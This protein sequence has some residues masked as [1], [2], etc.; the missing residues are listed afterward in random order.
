MER[1]MISRTMVVLPAAQVGRTF[2]TSDGIKLDE[3]LEAIE[4][5]RITLSDMGV[6]LE[7]AQLAVNYYGDI[8]VKYMSPQTERELAE[9]EG[10]KKTRQRWEYEEFLRMKEKYEGGAE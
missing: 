9:E 6:N 1:K 3:A 10:L 7:E 8:I 5:A 4:R 2:Q